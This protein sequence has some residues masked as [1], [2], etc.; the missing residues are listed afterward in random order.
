MGESMS[1]MDHAV[2]D[3]EKKIG[4]IVQ[5]SHLYRSEPWGYKSEEKFYNQCLEVDTVLTPH[6]ILDK[7]LNIEI[8]MGRIRSGKGYSDREIDIDILFYGEEQIHDHR[9]TVPH[10]RFH[11]RK[12]AIAPMNEI[13]GDF[14]HPV[15]GKT[16]TELLAECCDEGLVVPV[17]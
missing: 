11:L 10:P 6:E 9:L 4:R 2:R 7:I 12:F 5:L 17:A 14:I 16:V 13:A 3:I 1:L 8:E 15:F